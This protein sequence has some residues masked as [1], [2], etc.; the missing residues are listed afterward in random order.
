MARFF[1]LPT[2]R[3]FN[4]KPRVYDEKKEQME[5]RIKRIQAELEMEEHRDNPEHRR[6]EDFVR[7]QIR[8]SFQENRRIKKRSNM[9][10][11]IILAILVAIV[12]FLFYR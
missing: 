1:K 5:K 9:T 6:N 10:L 8:N 12:Y 11:L 7:Q 4:Y 3:Q 2:H